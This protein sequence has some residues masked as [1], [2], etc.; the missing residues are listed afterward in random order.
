MINNV[1]RSLGRSVGRL[2]GLSL[3]PY[4]LLNRNRYELA[5]KKIVLFKKMW[6]NKVKFLKYIDIS[7]E[8]AAYVQK[9][10]IIPCENVNMLYFWRDIFSA[11]LIVACFCLHPLKK[12]NFQFH[13]CSWDV[14]TCAKLKTNFQQCKAN[15]GSKVLFF[16]IFIHN[17]VY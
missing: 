14:L 11:Q 2:I 4:N 10:R 9:A 12:Y 15:L 6:C 8:K 1:G 5:V 17:L 3:C 16:I 7:S 13:K